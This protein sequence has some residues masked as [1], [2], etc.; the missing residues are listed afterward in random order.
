MKKAPIDTRKDL[1]EKIMI[2]GGTSMF[3]GFPTRIENDMIKLYRK[4]ILKGKA[5]GENAKVQ[6]KIIVI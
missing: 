6:I 5:Y 3:P 4:N 1:Y 2:S